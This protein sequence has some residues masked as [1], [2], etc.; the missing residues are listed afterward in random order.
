MFSLRAGSVAPGT[1]HPDRFLRHADEASRVD[2]EEADVRARRRRDGLPRGDLN[3]RRV[4]G[5][6]DVHDVVVDPFAEKQQR[7]AAAVHAGEILGQVPQLVQHAP[8]AVP[9]LHVFEVKRA[10]A[11]HGVVQGRRLDG[12]R[13]GPRLRDVGRRRGGERLLLVIDIERVERGGAELPPKKLVHGGE[14]EPPIAGELLRRIGPAARIQDRGHVVGAEILLD[15]LT[16]HAPD[17]YR[18]C[19]AGI[20]VIQHDHIDAPRKHLLVRP[21]VAAP[22]ASSERQRILP[23]HRDVDRRKHVDL[24]PLAVLEQLEIVLRQAA[25]E[26]AL[27]IG[28]HR[29]D[30]NVVDFGLKGDLRPLRGRRRGLGPEHG[31]GAGAPNAREEERNSMLQRNLPAL[32]WRSKAGLPMLN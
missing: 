1:H 24:L 21:D 31:R 32:E 23:L 12:I 17:K 18:P 30:V 4:P 22:L 25:N 13:W 6:E 16:R 2:G 20:E 3:V 15:E 7:L 10:G 11:L 26:I 8:G 9:A 29:V 27:L 28:D 19:E 5:A 14:Q